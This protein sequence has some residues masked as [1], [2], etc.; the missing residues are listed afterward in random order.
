MLPSIELRWALVH[1]AILALYGN[2]LN[3]VAAR[4]SARRRNRLGVAGPLAL[5]AAVAS[6]H[7]WVDR[8]TLPGLGLHR[9]G[10]RRGLLWGTLA[11]AILAVPPL[12]FFLAPYRRGTTIRFDEVSGI[13]R[14]ALLHRLLVTTPIL[15]ALAEE[16]AFRGSLQG[17][18]QRV[19]PGR[20]VATVTL[21]SLSFAC[22]HVAV[23]VRTL[24]AT[25]VVSGVAIPLPVALAG[26]LLGVFAGGL[27]FGGLYHRTGSLVGPVAGHWLV[28]ALMLLALYR[29]NAQG[30][31]Q[32][33]GVEGAIQEEDGS[34][35]DPGQGTGEQRAAGAP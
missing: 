11:G 20:P 5:V 33:H 2:A 9:Q 7:R 17:R 24:Q 13:G 8:G 25:N 28:D 34:Q 15:V 12:L 30:P 27:V 32:G 4:V 22:W 6:W 29:L 31:N 16:L 14:R 10:W 26:G 3:L 23:N 35:V 1:G 19:L 18:L 21:S